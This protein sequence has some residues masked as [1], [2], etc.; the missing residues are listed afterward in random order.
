[1]WTVA[2]LVTIQTVGVLVLAVAAER[3]LGEHRDLPA[4]RAIGLGTLPFGVV[5]L[6]Y[7][8]RVI[9]WEALA[10]GGPHPPDS[11]HVVRLVIARPELVT[12]HGLRIPSSREAWVIAWYSTTEPAFVADA[13]RHY[14]EH[15][16]SRAGIGMPQEHERLVALLRTTTRRL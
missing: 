1:M 12:G 10:T 4:W 5:S 3:Y 6:F 13:I 11:S 9:P 8:S 14:V 7:G 2:T 16:E 15:P